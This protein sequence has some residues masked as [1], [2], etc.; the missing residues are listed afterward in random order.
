MEIEAMV[1]Q[2]IFT[3]KILTL[4]SDNPGRSYTTKEL[5]ETKNLFSYIP[6]VKK[7]VELLTKQGF[8]KVKFRGSEFCY[9]VVTT[10]KK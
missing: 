8:I 7:S 5:V 2:N 3:K 10:Q 4:F 9:Q 1:S 6:Q